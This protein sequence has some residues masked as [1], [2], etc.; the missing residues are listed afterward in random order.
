MPLTNRLRPQVDQPVWE[1]M[2]FAPVTNAETH[3]MY[4]S[5][6]TGSRYIYWNMAQAVYRYDTFTDGFG[7]F[8][9]ALPT[10]PATTLGGTWKHDDGHYTMPL[11]S[12]GT[13]VFGAFLTGETALGYD[14][15]VLAGQG[16]G[17][18]RRITNVTHSHP[19]MD[20]PGTQH[21][22][23]LGIHWAG[24]HHRLSSQRYIR[25]CLELDSCLLRCH[26]LW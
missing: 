14:I 5:P 21:Q 11:S 10:S 24:C 20:C 9:N 3:N 1:W 17:Q 23:M 22:L 13:T 8:G 2:R 19:Q 18:T 12:S 16:A 7:L 25:W 15:K 26:L 4:Y 6:V